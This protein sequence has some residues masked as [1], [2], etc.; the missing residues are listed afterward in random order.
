MD[1]QPSFFPNN[2]VRFFNGK[3]GAVTVDSRCY[4]V[5]E[6][7]KDKQEWRFCTW[8]SESAMSVLVTLPTDP[9]QAELV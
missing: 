2:V 3:L 8:L 5:R 4:V 6:W 9:T 7:C 1:T